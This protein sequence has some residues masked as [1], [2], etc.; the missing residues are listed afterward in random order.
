MP[1]EIAAELAPTGVLRVGVNLS[2][3]LLVTGKAANGDP[4]GVSPDMGRAVADRIGVPVKYVTF[5]GPGQLADA[6]TQDVWDIGNIGAEP[7]RAE[8]ISFTPAYCEI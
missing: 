2:N 4:V 7:Q 1:L 5:P 3:F 6:A 8:T